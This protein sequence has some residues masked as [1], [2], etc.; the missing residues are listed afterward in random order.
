MSSGVKPDETCLKAYD[1]LK[2]GKKHKFVVYGLG[3]GN[4]TIT[5]L[6]QIK[7][8]EPGATDFETFVKELPERECRWGVYDMEYDQ[9]E[10]KRNKLVFVMWT[11]DDAPIRQKMIYASSKDALRKQLVGISAEIQAT[12]YDEITY[13]AVLEKCT[14][15]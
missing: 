2:L 15:R 9:G 14:R 5:T 1:E 7:L 11:P 10:G 3:E 8:D 4:K 12:S 13:E 6:K